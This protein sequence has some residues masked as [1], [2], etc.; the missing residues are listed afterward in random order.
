MLILNKEK[1][2]L[3]VP[4]YGFVEKPEFKGYKFGKSITIFSAEHH[5]W[6]CNIE[7]NSMSRVAQ[8]LIYDLIKDGVLIKVPNENKAERIEKLQSKI[9]ELEETIKRLEAN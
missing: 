5:K 3:L 9:K 8:D 1:E 4:K 2:S 6:S 7:F